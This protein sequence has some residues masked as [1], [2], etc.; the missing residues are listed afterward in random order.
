MEVN[1]NVLTVTMV[2]DARLNALIMDSAITPTGMNAFV[3]MNQVSF[4]FVLKKTNRRKQY[5]CMHEKKC[6]VHENMHEI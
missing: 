5:I 2:T 1:A 3:S 4:S 6:I